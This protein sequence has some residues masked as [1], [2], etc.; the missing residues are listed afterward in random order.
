MTRSEFTEL[1]KGSLNEAIIRASLYLRAELP[2]GNIKLVSLESILADGWDESVAYLVEKVYIDSDKINPCVDL[3]VED[4]DAETTTLRVHISGHE[5]RAY[6][7][8]WSGS[9][10]P[11]LKQINGD[12]LTNRANKEFPENWKINT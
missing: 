2:Q 10:G 1:T 9:V 7:C 4:F 3:V 8:T 11:Y 5:P 12:L 6:C